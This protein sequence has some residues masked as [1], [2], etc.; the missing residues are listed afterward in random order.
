MC[1]LEGAGAV[2]FQLLQAFM[3]AESSAKATSGTGQADASVPDTV[4]KQPTARLAP[5]DQVEVT[6]ASPI[7]AR[8]VHVHA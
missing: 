2:Q 8:R 1:R 3:A 6:H 7:F 4:R 5:L